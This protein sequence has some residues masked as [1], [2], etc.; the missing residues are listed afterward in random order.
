MSKDAVY[1]IDIA[2]RRF[3]AKPN[4]TAPPAAAVPVVDNF[5]QTYKPKV[6]TSLRS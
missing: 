3:H 6:V 4:I 2:G 5:A 1:T